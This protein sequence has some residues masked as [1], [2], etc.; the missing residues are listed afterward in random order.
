MLYT[1]PMLTTNQNTYAKN[2]KKGIQ[3]YHQRKPAY[4]ERGEK[5]S[6]KNNK[7]QVTNRQCIL[8]NKYFECKWTKHSNRKTD[9]KTRPIYMLPTKDSFHT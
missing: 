9:E 1:N 8:I 3:V 6:E 5:G 2:K 7:K 4:H